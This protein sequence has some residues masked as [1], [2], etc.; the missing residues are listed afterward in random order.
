M[1][2]LRLPIDVLLFLILSPAAASQSRDDPRQKWLTAQ[3]DS[4]VALYQDFHRNPE[5]SFREKATSK[6]LAA[7]LR[8]AG[9]TVTELVGGYGLVGVI[10]NGKGPTVLVRGDMD[11]LPVPEKTGLPYRSRIYTENKDGQAAGIMHACGHDIHMTNLVGTARYLAT[12]QDQWQGRVILIG[13]PAEERSGGAKAMLKAGLYEK[14][15]KPDYAIALHVTHDLETGKIGYG[16]GPVMA[17]VDSVDVTMYGRGGH[18]AAPHTTIDP[19]V[20]GAQLVLQ[21]QTIVA[22]EISPTDPSVITVGSIH[23]G[24]K[25]NIISDRCHLQITVRSYSK[26]VREHLKKAIIRKANAVA[27]GA[28]AKQPKVEFSEGT[29]ALVNDAGLARRSVVAMRRAVGAT[30]VIE[31]PKVMTAEDFARF[32]QGGVPVF[33]FRLGSIAPAR[34]AGFKK[35]GQISPSLHSSSYYPDAPETLRCGITA[36]TAVVLDLLPRK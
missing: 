15:G 9:A 2:V 12:H 33:M 5:L 4:L 31:F 26:A 36:M 30:N 8:E 3:L 10:E 32:S 21:L 24:N 23:A 6:R 11:A 19:V 13:Q 35:A 22:R 16:L 20:Q 17:N 14:W 29:P 7:A 25:H 27:M 34:M 1:K 28:R 18:G